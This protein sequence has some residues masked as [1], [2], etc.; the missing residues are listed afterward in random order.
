M[1]GPNRALRELCSGV[2]HVYCENCHKVAHLGLDLVLRLF[3]PFQAAAEPR[4]LPTHRRA[5]DGR[6]VARRTALQCSEAAWRP[7]FPAM[8]LGA[9]LRLDARRCARLAA[10]PLGCSAQRST[11]G[12]L[13]CDRTDGTSDTGTGPDDG[14]CSQRVHRAVAPA[15]RGSCR[16]VIAPHRSP[17][18]LHF[19]YIFRFI[20]FPTRSVSL[21][22]GSASGGGGPPPRCAPPSRS[23]SPGARLA[24]YRSCARQALR[25]LPDRPVQQTAYS[26]QR[27]RPDTVQ[28]DPEAML[29]RLMRTGLALACVPP[30]CA[31]I[32]PSLTRAA[33][34]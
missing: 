14:C 16:G 28:A 18:P 1:H 34:P 25:P 33:Y 19:S 32:R 30:A 15:T 2:L 24:Q 26:S 29:P 17:S 21:S 8:W 27:R 13:V 12:C 22:P 7:P 3:G 20:I 10:A 5:P 31:P 11:C 23:V 9:A 4:C 6:R